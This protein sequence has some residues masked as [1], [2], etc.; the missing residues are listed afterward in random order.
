MRFRFLVLTERISF[1]GVFFER[2][3]LYVCALSFFFSVSF[4][5]ARGDA[6]TC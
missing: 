2:A 3:K 1:Q 6:Y 5:G 4:E